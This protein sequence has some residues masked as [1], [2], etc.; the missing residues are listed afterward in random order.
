MRRQLF[1]PPRYLIQTRPV[2]ASPT[3]PQSLI[4]ARPRVTRPNPSAKQVINVHPTLTWLVALL[5]LLLLLL[6]S[7]LLLLL[8]LLELV[9]LSSLAL[10][11]WVAVMMIVAGISR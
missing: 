1:C 3:P 5:L 4:Q 8:L 10:K 6:L 7:L 2:V 9:I 11:L